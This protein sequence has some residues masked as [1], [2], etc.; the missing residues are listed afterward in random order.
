M[1]TYINSDVETLTL[2][3]LEEG[4]VNAIIFETKQEFK[5]FVLAHN[6][7]LLVSNARN[8]SDL[9]DSEIVEQYTALQN[10]LNS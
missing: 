4:K 1:K 3:Y 7:P 6:V 5:A 2:T 8:Y 10:Y 9:E